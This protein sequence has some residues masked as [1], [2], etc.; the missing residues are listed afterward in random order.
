LAIKKKS[1]VFGNFFTFKWQF[2][3]G[4]ASDQYKNVGTSNVLVN[5][6]GTK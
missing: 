6:N 4:S 2:S 5:N 3:G 1:Q